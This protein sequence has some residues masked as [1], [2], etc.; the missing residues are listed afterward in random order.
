MICRANTVADRKQ[1]QRQRSTAR[2]PG[3]LAPICAGC[4]AGL[5]VL[6]TAAAS[7]LVFDWRA[8]DAYKAEFRDNLL[9]LAQAVAS[10]IDGD[11]HRRITS[12]AQQQS[13]EYEAAIRPIRHMLRQI[14]GVKYIYTTIRRDG[15]IVFVLDAAEPGDHDGDG[16]DDQAKIFEVYGDVDD[17]MRESFATGRAAVM[18]SPFHDQWGD[19]ISGYAWF[20]DAAGR[21]VGVVGVDVTAHEYQQRLAKIENGAK[22]SLIPAALIALS[23][24]VGVGITFRISRQSRYERELAN[25]NLEHARQAAEDANRIKSEFLANMSHEIRTPMTAILG[26]AELLLEEGD[27]QRAPPH[28][29]QSLHTIQRNGEHLL[30]IINDILDLSKIESGKLEVAAVAVAPH[31]LISDVVASM[32]MRA[33]AKRLSLQIDWQSPLPATIQTDPVRLRQILVNLIGNATK[34]TDSG[35]IVLRVEINDK[36]RPSP[37]LEIAVQDTGIGISG[38]QMPRLFQSF[39][40]ADSS[41]SRRYGGTGLGLLISKRLAMSLGGDI[42]ADSQV[43]RGSTF[44]L[45]VATGPLEGIPRIDAPAMTVAEVPA[46]PQLANPEA[47]LGCRI[48]LAEDCADNRRMIAHILSKAGA[49][50]SCV[51]NGREAI[52]RL[53]DGSLAG[54][55]VQPPPC[56]VVLMD[57]QMPEIDGYRAA[58]LLREKG[59][60]LPIVALTA[61][62]M[63]GEREKCLA[64]GCSDYATKPIQRAKLIEQL[65]S[66]A[67]TSTSRAVQSC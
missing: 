35:G 57:M 27:I 22:L 5:A 55:L 18:Q 16:R 31:Q 21:P 26:H 9:R 52:E 49:E 3:W 67:P 25:A 11:L 48:L 30:S 42:V 63:T 20:H 32:Q 53:T 19:F 43:G 29:I 33:S 37:L 44:L 8:A 61:H 14:D 6:L 56:D 7:I 59:C 4:A 2:Q 62:A 23:T 12:P 38:E 65:A 60:T 17:A 28:R 36:S 10:Q 54:Q 1:P 13:P 39:S 46:K 24:A 66:W 58:R 41:T 40:Q 15:E 34:F 51:E 45:S 50:V 47:L 64:A